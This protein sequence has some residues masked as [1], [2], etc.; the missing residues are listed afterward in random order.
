MFIFRCLELLCGRCHYPSLLR[1]RWETHFFAFFNQENISYLI[2]SYLPHHIP[3]SHQFSFFFHQSCPS[4][5]LWLQPLWRRAPLYKLIFVQQLPRGHHNRQSSLLMTELNI[6]NLSIFQ[7]VFFFLSF[8][9][10]RLKRN[11]F[12]RWN[13]LTGNP[14][15]VFAN[16]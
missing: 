9:F 8:C 6:W 14:L 12:W 11:Q 16:L 7:I 5:F 3:L 2:V 1:R 10:V 13:F 4:F 15:L